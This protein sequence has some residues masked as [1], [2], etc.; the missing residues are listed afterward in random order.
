LSSS[1]SSSAAMDV[2]VKLTP[3]EQREKVC[4]SSYAAP[5]PPLLSPI[6]TSSHTLSRRATHHEQS[7]AN[8]LTLAGSPFYVHLCVS[9]LVSSCRIA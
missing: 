6:I 1:A 5:A 3:E 4:V 7:H 2:Y 8:P 9:P